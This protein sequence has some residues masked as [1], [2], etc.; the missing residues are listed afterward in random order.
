[1]WSVYVGVLLMTALYNLI[2]YF[3]IHERVYLLY[4]GYILAVMTLLGIVLGY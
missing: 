4:V 3:S 2:L 1:M